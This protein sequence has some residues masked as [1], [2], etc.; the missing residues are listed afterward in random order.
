MGVGGAPGVHG[1]S[2]H[3]GGAAGAAEE[4]RREVQP[5]DGRAQAQAGRQLAAARGAHQELQR[6]TGHGGRQQK[7]GRGKNVRG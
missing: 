6:P 7:G 5:R 3:G 2:P 1:V 4:P